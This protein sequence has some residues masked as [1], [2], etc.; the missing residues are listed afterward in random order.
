MN[1]GND[2]LRLLGKIIQ[3][4]GDVYLPVG[5][6]AAIQVTGLTPRQ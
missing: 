6:L 1:S 4:P 3:H 2:K 5:R